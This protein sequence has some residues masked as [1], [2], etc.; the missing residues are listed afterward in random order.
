MEK[1]RSTGRLYA[2]H[3]EKSYP[4]CIPEIAAT[5]H[6]GQP[7]F[8]KVWR[9]DQSNQVSYRIFIAEKASMP[10]SLLLGNRGQRVRRVLITGS[11]M[12]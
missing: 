2:Q 10:I 5:N 11:G 9:S 3:L 7:G 1:G 12:K 8:E 4:T 6:N